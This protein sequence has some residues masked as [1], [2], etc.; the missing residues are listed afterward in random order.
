MCL[1]KF[2]HIEKPD[3]SGFAYRNI[4]E[5]IKGGAGI[6]LFVAIELYNVAVPFKKRIVF[7]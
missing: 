1:G 3:F 4:K 5:K 2:V 6:V 7:P